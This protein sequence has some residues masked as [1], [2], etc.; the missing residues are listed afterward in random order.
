VNEGFD[1]VAKVRTQETDLM[2][3]NA[4]PA[5]AA[6]GMERLFIIQIHADSQWFFSAKIICCSKV[7]ITID[8]QKDKYNYN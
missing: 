7:K 8:G 4:V 6:P 2:E 1:M 3:R 5:N